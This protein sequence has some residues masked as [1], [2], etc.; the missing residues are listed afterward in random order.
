[1]AISEATYLKIL[2]ERNICPH[3]L[4]VIPE[5]KRV[6]SGRKSD[7]GFCSLECFSKY[8]VLEF[9]EKARLLKRRIPPPNEC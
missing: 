9:A 8:H 7:G 2:W 4:R 5:G 6:G 3:C 1:M